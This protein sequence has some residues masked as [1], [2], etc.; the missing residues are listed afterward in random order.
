MGKR[1]KPEA[2]EEP[3]KKKTLMDII[4]EKGGIPLPSQENQPEMPKASKKRKTSASNTSDK[5]IEAVPSKAPTDYTK[6]LKPKIVFV[7]GQI[8]IEKPD[9]AAINKQINEE[10]LKNNLPLRY[11]DSKRITSLS[12]KKLNHTSK[13]SD[14]DTELFY[15]ALEIFGLDFSFLEIVLRPRK[16]FEIKK[17]YNREEK[18]NPKRV[19]N[20]VNKKKNLPQML[21][22]LQLYKDENKKREE[23]FNHEPDKNE[24]EEQNKKYRAVLTSCDNIDNDE[25]ETKK[26]IKEL[27]LDHDISLREIGKPKD[28][29]KDND[30][31]MNVDENSI[32]KQKKTKKKPD[33]KV[34]DHKTEPAPATKKEENET[35]EQKEQSFFNEILKN[36]N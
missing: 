31:E 3:P 12:F 16:R 32:K 26:I 6:M 7:D 17:K 19:L 27:E 15:K 8:K 4:N 29:D 11:D 22:V 5:K 14:D 23:N 33:H 9:I 21:R 35:K 1:K 13:W 2:K 28:K 20:A 36:F 10:A 25:V 34:E 30:V 18:L 24:I